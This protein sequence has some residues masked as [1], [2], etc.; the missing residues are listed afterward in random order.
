MSFSGLRVLSLESRRAAQMEALIL[1]FGGDAFVAPSVQER[2]VDDH[3]EALRFVDRLET[4]EFDLVVCMTGAG[5]SFLRD[6]VVARMPVDRF[7][8][9][10]RRV[11]IVSRGPKPVPMLRE[12]G[13]PVA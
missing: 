1:R 12:L 6:L 4:D 2:A 9:A 7:A 10:L 8:A 5:L 11:T 3:G 13:V